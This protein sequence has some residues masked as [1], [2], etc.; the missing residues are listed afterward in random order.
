MPGVYAP[1]DYRA[2]GE[3]D[4]SG[5]GCETS[6]LIDLTANGHEAASRGAICVAS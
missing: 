5:K 1:P 2:H 4:E 3:R 6:S